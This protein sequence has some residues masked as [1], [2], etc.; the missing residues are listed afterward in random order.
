MMKFKKNNMNNMI[1][2]LFITLIISFSC[3]KRD[4]E[5]IGPDLAMASANFQLAEDS[6]KFNS[7]NSNFDNLGYNW[8][9]ASF[10]EKVS[11]EI[12][13]KGTQSKAFKI[14]K[15]TSN[16]LDSS[17]ALWTGTQ[18][19]IYF[20]IAGE[21]AIAELSVYGSDKKWYDTTTIIDVKGKSD[22][23]PDALI[24]WDMDLMS[25]TGLDKG[26]PYFNTAYYAAVDTVVQW[27]DI[28]LANLHDPVQGRYRSMLAKST[29]LNSFWTG[30]TYMSNISPAKA[31]TGNY[32]LP[33]SSG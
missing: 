4:K 30:G 20:F 19:G 9:K 1:F 18:S 33:G 14:V 23:G 3:T 12:K 26:G 17:T 22:Y 29:S 7:P 6:F 2:I 24:W 5:A 10:N 15:G 16:V 21:K 11:W 25:V 31:K 27:G 13:I 28:A 8:F 32:G